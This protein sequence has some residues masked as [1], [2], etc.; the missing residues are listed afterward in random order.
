MLVTTLEILLLLG[1][2]ALPLVPRKEKT[3]SHQ[4]ASTELSNYAVDENGHLE[5]INKP[6]DTSLFQ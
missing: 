3:K 4:Q 2:I 1:A 5:E 6:Q